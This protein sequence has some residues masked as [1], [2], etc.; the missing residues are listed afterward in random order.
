MPEPDDPALRLLR[1]KE[2]LSD[3]GRYR[4]NLWGR[5]VNLDENI[6]MKMRF[7]QELEA[8]L[9]ETRSAEPEPEPELRYGAVRT[10]I[11]ERL[12]AEP[13]GIDTAGLASMLRLRFGA[14]VH[15]KS[16]HG[17]LK[18][19]AAEGLAVRTGRT[20]RLRS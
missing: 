1:M 8:Q 9:E 5:L 7:V 20:W 3:L 10:A 11:L 4:R 18:R 6:T 16:H 17:A 12:S 15:P 14:T 13:D 2:E 19:L